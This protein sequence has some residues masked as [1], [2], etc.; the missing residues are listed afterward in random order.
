MDIAR[1]KFQ[2]FE[3]DVDDDTHSQPMEAAPMWHPIVSL[4]MVVKQVVV[5]RVTLPMVTLFIGAE[6]PI[7]EMSKIFL[8]ELLANNTSSWQSSTTLYGKRMIPTRRIWTDILRCYRVRQRVSWTWGYTQVS[9]GIGSG[10]CHSACASD[11]EFILHEKLRLHTPGCE[12]IDK[13]IEL[14]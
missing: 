14:G 12:P 11:V 3:G 6:D 9:M 5:V 1:E 10:Q 13:A 8:E 7:K 4:V 2:L